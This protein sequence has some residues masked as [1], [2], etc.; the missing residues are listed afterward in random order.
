MRVKSYELNSDYSLSQRRH[1]IKKEL[2]E[3]GYQSMF[4]NDVVVEI[5]RGRWR[6][7]YNGSER[8]IKSSLGDYV[9]KMEYEKLNMFEKRHVYKLFF[10]EKK[11]FEVISLNFWQN[12]KFLWIQNDHWLQKEENIRYAINISFLI[13]GLIIGILNFLK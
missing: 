12:Q 7:V 11:E 10:W 8:D 3:G 2:K 13:G 5:K 1:S 4:S 6:F 9:F